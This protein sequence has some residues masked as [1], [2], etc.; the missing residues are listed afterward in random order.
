MRFLD[1]AERRF[2]NIPR[3]VIGKIER[4]GRALSGVATCC[5]EVDLT[6]QFILHHVQLAGSAY[7]ECLF[8][9][10]PKLGARLR[11]KDRYILR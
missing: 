5:S 11:I 8:F 7:R 2:V 4:Q 10:R 9:E 6:P 1:W 3:P